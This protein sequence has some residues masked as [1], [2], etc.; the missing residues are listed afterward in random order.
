MKHA[1]IASIYI[2]EDNNLVVSTPSCGCCSNYYTSDEED[3][4]FTAEEI[5]VYLHNQVLSAEKILEDYLALKL[6]G[7]TG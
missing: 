1:S 5:R 3:F 4:P 2:T 6:E 7:P